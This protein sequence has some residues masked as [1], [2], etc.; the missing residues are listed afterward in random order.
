MYNTFL[1]LWQHASPAISAFLGTICIIFI[2]FKTIFIHYLYI[3]F[4]TS[5]T[6]Q[7]K[8]IL[9]PILIFL[10]LSLFSLLYN[11][12][13]IWIKRT[14]NGVSQHRISV[15]ISLT[16]I[17]AFECI[18]GSSSPAGTENLC[19][20]SLPFFSRTKLSFF[21]SSLLHIFSSNIIIIMCL[22]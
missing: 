20:H 3:L 1:L 14:T 18:I 2:M 21:R 12:F 19:L 15:R 11:S 7:D 10:K 9:N 13:S 6:V 16:T 5:T 8:R 17:G 22:L 4:S